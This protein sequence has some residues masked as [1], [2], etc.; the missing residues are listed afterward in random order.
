[1][2]GRE[3]ESMRDETISKS[4]TNN[5]CQSDRKYRALETPQLEPAFR[6]A[7]VDEGR[8]PQA[9]VRDKV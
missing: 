4:G 3:E 2:P 1:M 6:V 8:T 5:E 9:S 7:Q